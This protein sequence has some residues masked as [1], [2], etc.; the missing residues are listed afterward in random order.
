MVE[1]A[2]YTL[3]IWGRN[4]GEWPDNTDLSQVKD[5]WTYILFQHSNSRFLVFL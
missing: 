1:L 3:L 4:I 5:L 2:G